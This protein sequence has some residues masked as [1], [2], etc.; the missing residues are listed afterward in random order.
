M[1]TVSVVARDRS[2]VTENVVAVRVLDPGVH[3]RHLRQLAIHSA[4]MAILAPTLNRAL[5]TLFVSP[6]V[7]LT[8][9]NEILSL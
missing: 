1:R 3:A 5:E 4:A 2:T 9:P 8:Q 7:A 6:V